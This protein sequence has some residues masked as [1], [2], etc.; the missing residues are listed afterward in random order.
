M[1]MSK[2]LSRLPKP[3][4]SPRSWGGEAREETKSTPPSPPL[5]GGEHESS[6]PDKVGRGV[7]L[8]P[9][10]D[11]GRAGEGLDTAFLPYNKNLTTLARENR[12]NPT[13]AESKI[14]NEVLRLRQFA[15]YKFLRQKPLGSYIVDFYCSELRLV[16]EID[17]D[18]HADTIEYDG[19]RT[20]FLQSLGVSVVRYTNADVMRN[21]QGVHEDLCERIEKPPSL[22]RGEEK[23]PL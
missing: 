10:P 1:P 22:V 16:I 23:L 20:K 11:K 2:P 9:S 14:W 12:K 6:L 5:S 3:S 7:G 13:P 17:G 18:S 19:E 8:S 4:R 21:I 15:D